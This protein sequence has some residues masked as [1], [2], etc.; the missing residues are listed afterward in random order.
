MAK[1]PR[2]DS[3]LAALNP[4]QKALLRTWLI[5]ENLS[6]RDAKARLHDDFNITT[7]EG[8]LSQFYATECFAL[9]SSEAKEFAERVVEE[10]TESGE[11]FD[12]A[13]L[14]LIKQKAF[15][16]AYAKNGNIDELATLAKI[17]G[18]SAKLKLKEKD[19][20]LAERRISILEKKA[21]LADKAKDITSNS[22]LSDEEKAAQMRG[23]FGMG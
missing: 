17:L 15:E 9:R 14:A 18:D 13:T 2:S 19:Q 4:E 10:L 12:E 22:E 8:A 7:S 23:L 16:R 5:D 1:K 3:K 6:Y 21:A 20:A 11:K